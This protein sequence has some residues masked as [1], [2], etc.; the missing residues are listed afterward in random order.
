MKIYEFLQPVFDD[1]KKEIP[2]WKNIIFTKKG[3]WIFIPGIISM[4]FVYLADANGWKACIAKS[5]NEN[6]ALYLMSMV[7]LIMLIRVIIY[8]YHLDI[9]LFALSVSFL[10]REIH[11]T[12]THKGIYVAL[13]L[14]LIWGFFWRKHLFKDFASSKILKLFFAGMVWTYTLAILIQRRALRGI[15]P[16]ERKLHIPLEEVGENVS[17]LFF[18]AV[19]L[20]C[21]TLYKKQA[22]NKNKDED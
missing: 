10:C 11:F 17:H 12:G 3:I 1:F 2:T 22:M 13:T 14:I 15:I 16:Y 8:H 5:L 20:L 18:I 19:A 4:L 6:I 7:T 21:F 9:I